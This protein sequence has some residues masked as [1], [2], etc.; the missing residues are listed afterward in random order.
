[1]TPLRGGLMVCGTTSDA[2]K[3]ITVAGLCRVLAR[4]GVRVAPFKA[5]NMALNSGVTAT[6]HE[7]G[8]AQ[9][10]Q[11]EAAGVEPEVAMNPILLK[12][13]SDRVAQ[14]V[15]NGRP[16]GTMD[17]VEYH[18]HKPMLLRTVLASLADLRS[19]F[20]VVLLEGA[21]SPTEINL[22]A[23]DIVNL[24]IA[25]EAGLPA[26]VVGDIDRGGVFAAFYG[27]VALL[28]DHLRALVRGFVIN[29][30]RGDP[31]L[32]LDG[33]AQLEAACGVPTLGVVPMVPDLDLDAEDSL[34]LGQRRNNSTD[35][36]LDIAVVA[37]PYLANFT[38]FDALAAEPGVG[39]RYVRSV[40]ELGHPHLVILPGSKATVADLDWLR[41]TGLAD[42]VT[43]C[44]WQRIPVLG[45]CAGFQMLGETIDDPVESGAGQVPGLGLLP[46]ATT[47]EPDKVLRRSTGAALGVGLRGYQIHHGR[48]RPVGERAEPWL[49]FAGAVDGVR[50]E[51][52]FGTTV[53]GL[54][55]ADDFRRAFLAVVATA[56]GVTQP[57][58]A[59]EYRAVREAR[60][61]RL[62]DVFETHLDLDRIIDLIGSA[63]SG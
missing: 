29:K 37:L 58:S 19:R 44:A 46:V 53:H 43:A 15:L 41:A 38:D 59:V 28:P 26:L 61:D 42:A 2:G 54:F 48:V 20:D 30:F 32:L 51:R 17:A 62:A 40:G 4:R 47:F 34:A 3:S 5:Q 22:L 12:P 57:P 18:D 50:R 56:A 8:R 25:H 1:M 35:A 13:T 55:D 11:A 31:T 23:N 16:F 60:L 52:V 27:T 24:R 36:V 33:P 6:G 21:G 45:I 39:V 10:L 14:V 9:Y 7:I 63:G 49:V